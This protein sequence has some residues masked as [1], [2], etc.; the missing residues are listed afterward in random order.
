MMKKQIGQ[1]LAFGALLSLGVSSVAMAEEGNLSG[2]YYELTGIDP[3]EQVMQVDGN[4]IPAE[5]YF[6]WVANACSQVE[7]QINYSYHY[8]DTYGEFIDEDS[9][10]VK[11]EEELEGGQTVNQ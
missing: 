3:A 2:V 9:G 10:A 8:Y 6:Y 11:W 5:I 4:G 7:S 1:A